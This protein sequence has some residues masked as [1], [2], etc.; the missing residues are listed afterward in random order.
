MTNHRVYIINNIPAIKSHNVYH[1]LITYNQQLEIFRESTR[2][3][4]IIN[5]HGSWRWNVGEDIFHFSD[6]FRKTISAK[7]RKKILC[8]GSRKGD[9]L[10][11]PYFE[12]MTR[13]PKHE[14]D[15]AENV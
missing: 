12:R 9:V 5:K 1:A 7:K 15:S 6:N 14:P 11:K 10:K 8:L 2:Q 4:E 3:S 13:S